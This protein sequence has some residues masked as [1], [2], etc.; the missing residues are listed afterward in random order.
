LG[1]SGDFGYVGIDKSPATANP[2]VPAFQWD[3]NIYPGVYIQP[4]R[5]PNAN[6]LDPWGEGSS[7]V[8][9]S[10]LN[11]GRT[12]N[13]NLG[14]EYEIDRNTVFDFTYIG[15]HGSHLHESDL[16]PRNY[17]TW[18]QFQPLAAAGVDGNWI[19]S[20]A[21]ANTASA[22]CGCTVPWLS[23]LPTATN[24]YGGYTAGGS[25]APYPQVSAGNPILF[26]D[27]PLGVSNYHC[28]S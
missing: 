19:T 25:L 21:D 26:V 17:A 11:L 9:P 15:M 5:D 2:S 24:G 10:R 3:Q 7:Y 27:S 16:D 23:F 28:D 4:T 8:N 6:A 14:I 20:Q 12:Q 18:Q 22:K 1:G 13:W